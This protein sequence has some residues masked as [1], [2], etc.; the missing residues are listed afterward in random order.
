MLTAT[1]V[2]SAAVPGSRIAPITMSSTPA[3]ISPAER[4]QYHDGR[5]SSR[6]TILSARGFTYLLMTPAG[7]KPRDR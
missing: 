2:M 4:F 5:F 3:A 7:L 6:P 1:T